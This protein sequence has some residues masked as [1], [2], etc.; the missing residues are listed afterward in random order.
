MNPSACCHQCGNPLQEEDRFC[1]TCG[2]TILSPPP[3]AE[4]VI[5]QQEAASHAPSRRRRLPWVLAVSILAVLVVG[6]GAL[7]AVAFQDRLGFLG[8]P[9]TEPADESNN[10]QGNSEEAASP[11]EPTEPTSPETTQTPSTEKTTASTEEELYKEFGREYDEAVRQKDW[12]ATYSMLYETSQDEF[13]E[14]EWAEKQQALMDAEGPPASLD[15]VTV[16]QNKEASDSPATVILHYRDGTVETLTVTI[17]MAVQSGDD[18]GPKRILT[19]DEISEL[20]RLSTDSTV[21]EEES[22]EQQFI[23]D[24]YE[25][26]DNEDWTKTYSMLSEE[27]QAEFTEEEWVQAQQTREASSPLPPI[28]SATLSNIGGEGAGF[29]ADVVLTHD[30]GTE[31]TVEDVV[32]FFQDGEHKRYLTEEEIEYLSGLIEDTGTEEEAVEAAIRNHY[33]AVGNNDF[34]EAYSYFGSTFHSTNSEED[35]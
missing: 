1:G 32:V 19:E 16:D 10:P 12:S 13:T 5:P 20:E 6:T 23:S 18:T 33:E 8:E 29:T 22:V 7:A 35:W 34:E 9:N 4:Q 28:E 24:Y 31:T 3:Q 30:D 17:P 26:V 2:A 15:F 25:A 11:P 14:G 27:S 21:P